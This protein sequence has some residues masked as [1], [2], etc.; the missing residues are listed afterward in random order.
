M[1]YF[2]CPSEP[3]ANDDLPGCCL[4]IIACEV[5]SFSILGFCF[6]LRTN[7]LSFAEVFKVACDLS[8]AELDPLLFSTILWC[9][10]G[11][12]LGF[13]IIFEGYGY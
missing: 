6:E 5:F 7:Q 9:S 1:K 4:Q 3:I 12:P 8:D 10:N 13:A 2:D 11:F